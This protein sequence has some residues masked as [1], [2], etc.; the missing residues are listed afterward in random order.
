MDILNFISW[1]RGRR[2]V[3]LVDPAKTLIPIGLK[4]GRRDDEY[5]AG[6]IT[7]QDLAAQIAPPPVNV[8]NSNGTLT[9]N[10]LINCAGNEFAMINSTAYAYLGTGFQMDLSNGSLSIV[11]GGNSTGLIYKLFSSVVAGPLLT[12]GRY[13]GSGV[14][15]NLK[16]NHAQNVAGFSNNRSDTAF[17]YNGLKV[18][19]EN[20]VYQFGQ[21]TGSNTTN[22]TINDAAT[23]PVQVSGT[24]VTANTAGTASGEFLKI[25]V[26]GVDYKIAL[27]NP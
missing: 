26:N 24:N 9:G 18:D 12:L 5:L 11:S 8:Y 2:Q 6:A 4:D 21:I 23:Y 22:I 14:L 27:L 13:Q 16:F 3:T 17:N 15:L 1:I 19:I 10:R 7:V 25:K 20:R